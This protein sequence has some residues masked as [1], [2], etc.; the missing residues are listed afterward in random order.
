MRVCGQRCKEWVLRNIISSAARITTFGKY[1]M[2]L[3]VPLETFGE[4]KTLK[5]DDQS[6]RGSRR[7]Q[8]RILYLLNDVLHHSKY[9]L[10]SPLPHS[11]LT[12]SLRSY[13]I[14][15]TRIASAYNVKKFKNHHKKIQE[16][17]NLWT[18]RDYFDPPYIQKLRETVASSLSSRCIGSPKYSSQVHEGSNN[19]TVNAPYI[20][21]S[22]HGDISTPY[23]DLPAGNMMPHIIPNLANPINPQYMKPLQFVSGAAEGTLVIALKEFLKDVNQ[24]EKQ[25]N[26][27]ENRWDIDELGS[28]VIRDA[29]TGDLLQGEG[30]Y[31]WS[32][33]FCEKM[34][35]RHKAPGNSVQLIGKIRRD[36]ERRSPRKRRRYSSSESSRGWD[37]GRS[38]SP[39]PSRSN[40]AEPKRFSHYE[41]NTEPRSRSGSVSRDK[42]S[43]KNTKQLRYRA[44]SPIRSRSVS[45]SSSNS[46][47]PPPNVPVLNQHQSSTMLPLPPPIPSGQDMPGLSP[48]PFLQT[49]HPDFPLT[50][51][52][53][54]IPPP[55]P[56]YRGP[57]PPPPPPPPSLAQHSNLPSARKSFSAILS[58]SSPTSLPQ[59]QGQMPT[60]H[61]A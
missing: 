57:W 41:I 29:M 52:G 36:E 28:V 8:L 27:D 59:G 19:Q 34:K 48:P 7:K 51:G 39:T 12:T 21:P 4:E 23:Y 54:P 6:R 61:N 49:F 16:L 3:S 35:R 45:T 53:L 22:S 1:L 2:V 14:D 40:L 33:V 60:G 46:Y 31:G 43:I 56:N 5:S 25:P 13:L 17:L 44:R 42:W 24:N 26:G 18:E 55:P 10:E 50:S 9:H 38:R 58:S 15:L 37:R 20:M 11:I 32:R 47:S 30:Y